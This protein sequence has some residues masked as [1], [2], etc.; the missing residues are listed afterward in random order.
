MA[1]TKIG[2]GSDE[3]VLQISQ[4]F[5]LENAQYRVT[6][7]GVQYGGTLEAASLHGS[8]QS[9]TLTISGD[10]QAGLH[11]VSVTLLNDAWG[12]TADTD[13]NLNDYYDATAGIDRNLYLDSATYNGLAVQNSTATL[14]NGDPVD[15]TF[16]EPGPILP[17]FTPISTTVGSGPDSLVLKISQ[18]GVEPAYAQYTVSVDGVQVG[19]VLN[20]S[21]LHGSGESDILTVQGDWGTGQHAVSVNFLNDYYSPESGLDR[22]LY[23][24]GA[25]YNGEAVQGST[26][27]L[28]SSGAAGFTFADG[29]TA[30]P[31]TTANPEPS[32]TD[33]IDWSALAAQAFA[34]FEATGQW[35]M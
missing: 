5:Y 12:G 21:A 16:T 6:V 25:T 8:G 4:D 14:L 35:F 24:D 22:N 32:A 10:W 3:L 23:L 33:P 2:N 20:A 27:A 11:V 31:P 28:L 29:P 15:F 9:D 18:D 1:A 30:T 13:L 26:A 34:N 17:V 19:G 7:D